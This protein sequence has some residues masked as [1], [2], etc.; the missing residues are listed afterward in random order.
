MASGIP[1]RW[2]SKDVRLIY[3]ASTRALACLENVVHRSALGLQTRFRTMVIEIP[4]DVF[5]KVIS[6]EELPPNWF[7]FEN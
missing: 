4:E 2:N 7:L 3:T 1:A 6:T 5:I